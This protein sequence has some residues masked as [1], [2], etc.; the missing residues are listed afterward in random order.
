[1]RKCKGAI[2]K[3]FEHNLRVQLSDAS[4]VQLQVH[5]NVGDFKFG[6]ISPH[7]KLAEA[8]NRLYTC[9]ERVN[10]VVGIL[11]LCRFNTQKELCDLVVNLGNRAVLETICNLIY[12]NDDKFR[13]VNGLILSDNG[14]TTVAPLAVF[15]GAEF[16]VLDLSKNKV[17]T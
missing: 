9:M 1:M 8:L 15:A 17:K 10:G 13:L 16:V 3:L 6:Q 11:N 7:A 14:I 2:N 5:F 4:F 12:R